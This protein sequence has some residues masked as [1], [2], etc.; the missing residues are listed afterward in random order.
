MP[1][2][3]TNKGD[4]SLLAFRCDSS[5]PRYPAATYCTGWMFLCFFDQDYKVC[6]PAARPR[7]AQYGRFRITALVPVM[8]YR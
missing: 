3:T 7:Q 1:N 5:S 6:S 2:I 4:R 8:E